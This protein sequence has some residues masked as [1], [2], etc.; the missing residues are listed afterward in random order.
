M[1]KCKTCKWYFKKMCKFNPPVIVVIK[2]EA[3]AGWANCEPDNFCSKHQAKPKRKK[4]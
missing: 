4:K 2:N 3:I 1:S